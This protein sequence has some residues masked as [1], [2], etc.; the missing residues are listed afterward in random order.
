[1][2]PERTESAQVFKLSLWV[3][4]EAARKRRSRNIS[5]APAPGGGFSDEHITRWHLTRNFS[6]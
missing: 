1:M 4:M 5:L 2:T 3:W 6:L